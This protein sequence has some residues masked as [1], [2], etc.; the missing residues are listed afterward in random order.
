MVRKYIR[1]GLD[2]VL[3]VHFIYDETKVFDISIF[4]FLFF[5]FWHFVFLTF[6]FLT[7]QFLTFQFLTFCFLTIQ[8]LTFQ[9]LT[10][11]FL[12]FQLQWI[13]FPLSMSQQ[14]V[15]ASSGRLSAS[16]CPEVWLGKCSEE[17]NVACWI[18][19]EM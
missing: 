16:F 14:F 13:H 7:F 4:Y 9:F 1:L 17:C 8:F 19:C 2:M 10:F 5:V 11:H 12:T 18:I 3:L 15:H 6:Q